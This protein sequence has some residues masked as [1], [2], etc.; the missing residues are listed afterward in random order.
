MA[1]KN[2]VQKPQPA[3]VAPGGFEAP[4]APTATIAATP[5]KADPEV[6]AE[7]SVAAAGVAASTAVAKVSANS[8]MLAGK[9]ETLF[10]GFENAIPG[11]EFG[12]LPRLV[13]SNG[14]VQVKGSNALIGDVIGL[15]LLSWNNT[16]VVSPGDDTPEA[17]D[18]V[19]YSKDG[20]TIEES[21]QSVN[22]Y[23][24]FLRTEGYEKANVK[25]YVEL[26]GILTE[27]AKPCEHT[28]D[29]VQVSLSPQAAKSFESYRLQASVKIR[30][31]MLKPDGLESF[32][33]RAEVKTTA[34]NTYTLLK[35]TD[36]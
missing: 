21:G 32:K 12:V 16:W 18:A 19:A 31:G 34:G 15:Q 14:N 28:G 13:G 24:A 27:S 20:V 8:L 23:L 29:M 36:K 2:A 7:A 30:M 4:D 33:I 26:I 1:L 11:V 17:K 22:E 10:A 9:L 25:K 3:A 5:R 35:V 6:M